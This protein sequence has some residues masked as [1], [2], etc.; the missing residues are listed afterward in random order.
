MDEAKIHLK[1]QIKALYNLVTLNLFTHITNNSCKFDQDELENVEASSL[2]HFSPSLFTAKDNILEPLKAA[3]IVT[4][5]QSKMILDSS[6]GF[7]ELLD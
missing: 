5:D 6:Q 7:G 2:N 4:I 1:D 3:G